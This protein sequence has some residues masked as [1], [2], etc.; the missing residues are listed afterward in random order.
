MTVE[1][2]AA[3]QRTHLA[4]LVSRFLLRDAVQRRFGARLTT[5]NTGIEKDGAFYLFTLRLVPIF[6]F[7]VI[8]L[9]M[10]LTPIKPLTFYWVSQVG[11]LAGTLVYVNAGTQL[12]RLDSLSGILSPALLGS[13]ALFGVFP[14]LAKWVVDR[15]KVGGIKRF[16]VDDRVI[17]R[18]T[19]TDPEDERTEPSPG[20]L[21]VMAEQ[22]VRDSETARRRRAPTIRRNTTGDAVLRDHTPN[23][24]LKPFL[25]L[26][27]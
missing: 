24:C 10:G 27:P 8:N 9:L 5:L 15:I 17:P 3:E 13:F 19:F 2:S 23:T 6:P 20:S 21:A 25:G 4:F 18:V 14:L 12:A 11:M 22:R 26:K 1:R 7:F 16:K